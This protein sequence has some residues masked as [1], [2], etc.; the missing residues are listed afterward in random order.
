MFEDAPGEQ[1]PFVFDDVIGEQ[2]GPSHEVSDSDQG[3]LQ[4]LGGTKE[5]RDRYAE[6]EDSL[7][8][9]SD[10]GDE[11]EHG[12]DDGRDQEPDVTKKEP[13]PDCDPPRSTYLLFARALPNNGTAAVKAVLQDLV[14]YLQAHGL[15]IYRLHSD[16][17]ET[18]NHSIRS[19]LRDQGIR[20]TWSEPGIPQGN[21]QAETTVRWVK[22]KARS[23]LIGAK[24][25]TRLWPAAAEAATALQRAKVLNWKSSFLAPFGAYVHIKQKVFDS[26][27]PRRRERER[28]NHDGLVDNTW[29]FPTCLR[30][31]T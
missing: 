13:F 4:F 20:A 11:E 8:Q 19:W 6:E 18:Y 29:V 5:Q 30:A 23:L 22:D 10:P 24:L 15:P 14:L 12:L 2:S 21:G 3:G 27:G 16:K 1:G 9:P 17:G 26:S 28:S 25:P 7:Y 31:A